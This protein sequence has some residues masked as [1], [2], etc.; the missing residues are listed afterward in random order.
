[1]SGP[2]KAIYGE[3]ERYV[4]I[5][6]GAYTFDVPDGIPL[7]RAF[8]FIQFELGRMTCDWSR[9]CFNDTIGCCHFEFR[10]PSDAAADWGRACCQRVVAGLEVFT[11]PKGS[12][13]LDEA[14]Q[15]VESIAAAPARERPLSARQRAAAAGGAAASTTTVRSGSLS[16]EESEPA[17]EDDEEDTLAAACL[18][19]FDDFFFFLGA[20]GPGWGG[21]PAAPPPG[22]RI[23]PSAPR[24]AALR[25]AGVEPGAMLARTRRTIMVSQGAVLESS[26]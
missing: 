2:N 12:V 5:R 26:S 20:G 1:M 3:I 25:F 13:L 18:F 19:P 8:Q 4:P 24:L 15:P 9:F 23:W 10:G 17:L 16:E 11:L 6:I 14:G 21:R 22:T 7:I